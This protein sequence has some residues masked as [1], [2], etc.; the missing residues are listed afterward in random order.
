MSERS[1]HAYEFVPDLPPPVFEGAP[2]PVREFQVRT[3]I[4]DSLFMRSDA[5]PESLSTGEGASIE[6]VVQEFEACDEPIDVKNGRLLGLVAAMT[7]EGLVESSTLDKWQLTPHIAMLNAIGAALS[8]GLAVSGEALR[9]AV[10]LH[11][12]YRGR[13]AEVSDGSYPLP[14]ADPVVHEIKRTMT[15]YA[16]SDLIRD[17]RGVGRYLSYYLYD[18]D[19]NLYDLPVTIETLSAY[20]KDEYARP[21][22]SAYETI[23]AQV[24]ATRRQALEREAELN[25]HLERVYERITR[26]EAAR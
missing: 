15:H 5:L 25:E 11:G 18:I 2:L 7:E 24:A 8:A 23:I 4:N 6:D 17:E 26:L 19:K 12:E 9:K 22:V 21:L 16:G 1:P 13:S 20:E 14:G 3:V 10:I